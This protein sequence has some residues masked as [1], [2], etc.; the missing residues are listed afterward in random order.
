MLVLKS[1]RLLLRDFTLEDWQDVHAY[2]SQPEAYRFQAWEPDTPEESRAYV[3]GVV[4][5]AQARPRT[6]YQLAI[7]FPPTGTVIGAGG[8]A[9]RNQ[10]FRSGELSYQRGEEVATPV[11]NTGTEAEGIAIAAP[12]RS[13][14]ILAAIRDTH[15]TIITVSETAIAEARSTLAAKG[16]YVE[17]TAAVTYAGFVTVLKQ[18]EGT[19]QTEPASALFTQNVLSAASRGSVVIALCGVGLK[20][21]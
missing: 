20:A 13:R 14:H 19:R 6:A 7:V 10:R 3:E 9:I 17:P 1:P 2:A 8:L 11:A 4:T 12:A 16:L 5:L 15:G 21:A 18:G